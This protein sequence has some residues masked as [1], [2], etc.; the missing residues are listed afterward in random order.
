MRLLFVTQ[1]IVSPCWCCCLQDEVAS[2]ESRLSTLVEG[3]TL[4][5][6]IQRRWLYLEP[7]FGRG[8]LPAVAGRFR[9]VDGEF[10]AIMAQLAV[11][12]SVLDWART[13]DCM[14]HHAGF[15]VVL[16]GKACA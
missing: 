3:L 4:L 11:S 8:A 13:L 14:F 9:H 12:I 16:A 1:A 7:I 5:Q 2:W 6:G 15:A 10:R